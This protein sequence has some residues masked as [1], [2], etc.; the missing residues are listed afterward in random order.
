[1]NP[2]N[3]QPEDL[4]SDESF[5]AWFKQSAPQHVRYWNDWIRQHPEKKAEVEAAVRL[6][7]LLELKEVRPAYEHTLQAKE[8]LMAS[9]RAHEESKTRVIPLYRRKSFVWASAASV[10]AIF[11]LVSWLF[12]LNRAPQYVTHF[13]ERKAVT[14]PDGSQVILNANSH[15]RL[16]SHWEPESTR[17]VWLDGEG[18]FSVKHTTRSTRFIVHTGELNVEVLGTEFNLQ[19][20]SL[21]TVVVL[22]SGKVQLTRTDKVE[23]PA[24]VMKPG[25]LVEYRDNTKQVVRKIVNANIYSAWT[26]GKLVFENTSIEEIAQLLE[27]NYGVKV[28]IDDLALKGKQ[29]NGVFPTNNLP[30]LLKA[31]SKAYDL[32]IQVNNKRIKIR[33]KVSPP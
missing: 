22:K 12:W 32:D 1:M 23:A 31:L 9:V 30:V 5:V 17:E 10:A 3:I 21:R 6:L 27:E 15:L 20:R 14:L 13:G 28:D 11:L 25:D 7:E 8:R 26:E 19:K 4:I 18:Y 16:A 29:F 33:N 2:N 24:L